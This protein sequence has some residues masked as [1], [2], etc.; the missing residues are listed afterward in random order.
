MKVLIG[1]KMQKIQIQIS[2]V[3]EGSFLHKKIILL[4]CVE[5][6]WLSIYLSNSYVDLIFS[7]WDITTKVYEMV[8]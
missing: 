1:Q 2:R 6:N 3:Q 4:F 5:I 7:I 8:Y